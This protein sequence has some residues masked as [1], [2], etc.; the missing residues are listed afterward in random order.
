M[1]QCSFLPL[2]VAWKPCDIK[3]CSQ[4][5][6]TVYVITSTYTAFAF[7]FVLIQ[8]LGLQNHETK[9]LASPDKH[10]TQN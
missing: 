5:L 9:Q 8:V 1:L 10:K 6:L 4:F 7:T 3:L 2:K